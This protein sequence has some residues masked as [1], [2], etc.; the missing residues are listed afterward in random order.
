MEIIYVIVSFVPLLQRSLLRHIQRVQLLFVCQSW[1]LHWCQHSD[2]YRGKTFYYP[3]GSHK[4]FGFFYIS[5]RFRFKE[6]ENNFHLLWSKG[7]LSLFFH[8]KIQSCCLGVQNKMEIIR[9]KTR[10]INISSDS[11]HPSTYDVFKISS[12]FIFSLLLRE[13]KATWSVRFKVGWPNHRNAK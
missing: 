12:P 1:N 6:F 2:T 10:N 3:E 5:M 4:V 8:S 13:D 7:V 11:E 9:W